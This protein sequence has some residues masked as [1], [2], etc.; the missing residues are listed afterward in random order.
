MTWI[1]YIEYSCNSKGTH[2]IHNVVASSQFPGQIRVT[3]ELIGGATATGVL[4]V[5]YSLNSSSSQ[6]IQY[7]A[8][9]AK[10]D[11]ISLNVTGLTE[12]EYGVSTF[13]LENGLPFPRVVASTK[14]IAVLNSRQSWWISMHCIMTLQGLPLIITDRAPLIE[15]ELATMNSSHVCITCTFLEST[16]TH[17]V[18]VVHQRISQLS[19]SGLMNIESSHKFT[20]SVD[21][22]YGCIEGVNLEQYQI[23]VIGGKM[24]IMEPKSEITIIFMITHRFSWLF[25]PHTHNLGKNR[26]STITGAIIGSKYWYCIIV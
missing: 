9:Q 22:A 25:Y 19:S 1:N 13:A 24:I 18:A 8:K 12:A 26:E 17:C 16:T 5:V 6:D 15:Y 23:G 7:I 3:G 10:G 20:R 2:D 14:N 4:V 11:M 21:T